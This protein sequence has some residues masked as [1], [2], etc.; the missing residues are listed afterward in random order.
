MLNYS[1]YPPANASKH[2][3]TQVPPLSV[4]WKPLPNHSAAAVLF[5]RNGGGSSKISF[6]FDELQWNGARA[7]ASANNCRV[8]SVWDGGKEVGTFSGGFEA[9]V[10]GSA[11]FFAIVSG[12]GAA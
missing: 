7:L 1:L 3:V 5:N 12:C 9:E 6:R 11:A 8:R 2:N 10:S 4:W